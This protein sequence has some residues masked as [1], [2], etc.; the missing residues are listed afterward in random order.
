MIPE[1]IWQQLDQLQA[2][3]VQTWVWRAVLNPLI[4]AAVT[5]WVLPRGIDSIFRAEPAPSSP[6][7]PDPNQPPIV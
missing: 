4:T 2:R 7:Q 3:A 5:R 1:R 6:E